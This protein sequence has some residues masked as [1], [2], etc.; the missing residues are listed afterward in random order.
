MV[1]ATPT[2]RPIKDIT[3]TMPAVYESNLIHLVLELLAISLTFSIAMVALSKVVVSLVT[4][5]TNICISV[6]NLLGQEVMV[7]APNA[8]QTTL[9]VSNLN[10]GVYLVR[11]TSQG[12]VA[13]S[14]L[15]KR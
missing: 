6:F 13:T 14:R 10:S 7:A 15:I 12:K 9:D 4:A 2:A 8:V 3:L 11:T 5:V 1:Q